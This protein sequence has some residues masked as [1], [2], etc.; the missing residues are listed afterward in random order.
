[1]SC[2][3]GML[4]A[5][6]LLFFLLKLV[7]SRQVD[8]LEDSVDALEKEYFGKLKVVQDLKSE[9]DSLERR[10]LD[11]REQV[12]ELAQNRQQVVEEKKLKERSIE[13]LKL[14]L[15]TGEESQVEELEKTLETLSHTL[16]ET[17]IEYRNT[18]LHLEKLRSSVET[19]SE[20]RLLR[21][22]VEWFSP[23]Q[24]SLVPSISNLILVF[25]SVIKICGNIS[26]MMVRLFS[27]FIQ[28]KDWLNFLEALCTWWLMALFVILQMRLVLG[29]FFSWFF[30][31][32][33]PWVSMFDYRKDCYLGS[34]LVG[35]SFSFCLWDF[36]TD[37]EKFL[38]ATVSQVVVLHCSM[39]WDTLLSVSHLYI[40]VDVFLPTL[41]QKSRGLFFCYWIPKL[42]M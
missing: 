22:L 8:E 38:I 36:L 2:R 15:Q 33:L 24:P 25:R 14:Q 28:Q 18:L 13:S 11:R 12:K 6:L 1:M 3:V 35:S 20:Q 5:L 19:D 34:H 42:V 29:S 40:P 37:L 27:F 23:C 39:R 26:C 30:L 21:L 9:R 31:T 17:E 32:G 41:L 4:Y 16:E 7:V 10:I